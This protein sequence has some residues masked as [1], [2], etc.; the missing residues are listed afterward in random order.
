ML[1][2]GFI[3]FDGGGRGNA[4]ALMATSLTTVPSCTVRIE[5]CIHQFASLG[6]N[7]GELDQHYLAS[8][9][10]STRSKNSTLARNLPRCFNSLNRRTTLSDRGPVPSQRE[11]C[12]PSSWIFGRPEPGRNPPRLEPIFIVFRSQHCKN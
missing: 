10:F 9:K 6:P 7:L 1:E 2:T 3:L 11:H 5:K 4:N 8:Q 12:F